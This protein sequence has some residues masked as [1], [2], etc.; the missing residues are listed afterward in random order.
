MTHIQTRNG[1]Y[2]AHKVELD[3]YR[4]DSRA[5]ARRYQDL[6]LMEK[7]G[8][9]A[10]LEF[11]P[12]YPGLVNGKHICDYYADFRYFD[13]AAGGYIVEDVKGVR[14]DVFILKKKLV[15]AIYGIKIREVK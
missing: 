4:F 15:E 13:Y 2:N 8:E 5:E 10:G 9:I 12:K 7:A 6:K 1:K 14:T 11:Q 3:G